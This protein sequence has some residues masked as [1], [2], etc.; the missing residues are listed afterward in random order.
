MKTA[1]EVQAHILLK[2]AEDAEFRAHLANDP[3][4][5]IETETGVIIP[6]DV[7]VHINAAVEEG[8]DAYDPQDEALTEAELTQVMG[9]HHSIWQKHGNYQ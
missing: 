6:D 4:K 3:K 1:A 2:A 9:G 7:M 8:W 5:T